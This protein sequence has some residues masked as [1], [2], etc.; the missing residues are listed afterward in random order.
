MLSRKIQANWLSTS[1]SV[2]SLPQMR[3]ALD[4]WSSLSKIGGFVLYSMYSDNKSPFMH[5]QIF[6]HDDIQHVI[7]RWVSFSNSL[8]IHKEILSCIATCT[9]DSMIT[10]WILILSYPSNKKLSWPRNIDPRQNLLFPSRY[11]Y[12]TSEGGWNSKQTGY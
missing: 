9:R 12:G 11:S 3:L 7:I 2:F 5:V 10:I 1:E 6:Y 8:S 4:L